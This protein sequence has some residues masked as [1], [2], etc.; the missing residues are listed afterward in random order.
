VRCF[1]DLKDDVVSLFHRQ[2]YGI[3]AVM[4][5]GAVGVGERGVG[6]NPRPARVPVLWV[7][8]CG[9]TTKRFP[10]CPYGCLAVGSHGIPAQRVVDKE[11]S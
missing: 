10:H 7:G 2:S 6:E 11:Q 8:R 3:Q 5:C 1:T 9:R 4:L